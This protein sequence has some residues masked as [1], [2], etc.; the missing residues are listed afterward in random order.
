ME[1]TKPTPNNI[2]LKF[3]LASILIYSLLGLFGGVPA[4]ANIEPFIIG[5]V[6][7]FLMVA[8]FLGFAW[9][10][11]AS[12]MPKDLAPSK[13]KPLPHGLRQGVAIFLTLMS[14]VG[15]AGGIW[16]VTWHVR[17][18][19]PFGEDFFWRPHQFIYIALLAPVLVAGFI[20]SRLLYNTTGTARQRLRADIP[21]TLIMLGGM[22]MLFTLPAD[23]VWHVI[24][25]E[26]LTGLSVPH[27]VFSVS[28]TLTGLGTFAILLS[29]MPLRNTW[30][31]IRKINGI[32]LLMALSFA[33]NI[34]SLLMPTLG[35]WEAISIPSSALQRLPALVAQR[36]DWAMPFLAAFVVIYPASMALHV[37][38]RFGTA[39]LVWGIA[40]IIRSVMFLAFGYDHTGIFTMFLL[41]PFALALDLVTWYRVS[42]SQPVS[43]LLVAAVSTVVSAVTVLPQIVLSF[44]LP[45]LSVSNVP[46]MLA[47]IFVAALLAS[48]MGQV[49][50]NVVTNTRRF[51]MPAGQPVI[52]PSVI[53]SMSVLAMVIVGVAILF[54]VTSTIPGLMTP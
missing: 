25:G 18:G 34:I 44:T 1:Q 21:L 51:E 33:F 31:S 3:L 16:D 42:R 40:T 36:P 54:I 2:V 53:R 48:W 13:D 28:S 30:E 14:V 9:Y 10:A 23:P 22:A 15:I 52:A 45:V 37:M 29:Y 6:V 46:L 38:K 26:D 50:G 12:P 35:D 41:L 32:E 24:Y 20:A 39:T 4:K 5:L 11:I 43:P 17:S 19:L 27:F 49:L 7:L 8:A 47:T